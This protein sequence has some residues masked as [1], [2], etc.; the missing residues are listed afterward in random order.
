MNRG[1]LALLGRTA[2]YLQ[3]AQV[4]QR[5]RLRAQR[6]A[7]GRWPQLGQRLLADPSPA[8]GRVGWPTSFT[9]LDALTPQL[10][11]TLDEFGAGRIRLLRMAR[12]LG[13]P[14]DWQQAD[15]PQLWRFHPH[16]YDRGWGL[17]GHA[18]PPAAPALLS[19]PCGARH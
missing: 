8:A 1:E 2:V 5:A 10:C 18:A 3:P 16:Y 14:A 6:A 19:R 17:G 11:P 13:D 9:P 12:D 15:A 4:G 7:L